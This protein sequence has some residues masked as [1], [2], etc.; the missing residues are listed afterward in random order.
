MNLI[1]SVDYHDSYGSAAEHNDNLAE[2]ILNSQL[3][4][5]SPILRL[6]YNI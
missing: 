5:L 2:M 1:W 4:K 6:A 3:F